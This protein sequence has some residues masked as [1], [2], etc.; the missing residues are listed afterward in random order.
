MDRVAEMNEALASATVIRRIEYRTCLSSGRCDALIELVDAAPISKV[1]VTITA[2]DIMR[3]S[4][5]ELGGGISQLMCLRVTDVSD[6][7]HDRVRYLLEDLE[8]QRLEIRCAALSVHR[9]TEV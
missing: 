9:A 3:W 5:S 6:A 8:D 2:H 4:L 1:C 7:Q